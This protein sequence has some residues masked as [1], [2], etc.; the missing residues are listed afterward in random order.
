MRKVV[1]REQLP[2]YPRFVVRFPLNELGH[3]E[4]SGAPVD[5]GV[6]FP[7]QEDEV[8][9]AVVRASWRL[10]VASWAAAVLRD[11]MRDL[12]DQYAF[13]HLVVVGDQVLAAGRMGT[14]CGRTAPEDRLVSSRHCH[15]LS[16]LGRLLPTGVHC[17]TTLS[18][19]TGAKRHHPQG[20]S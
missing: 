16:P 2:V 6:V 18:L 1:V 20:A 10:L 9:L 17:T 8:R 11:D 15:F 14:P 19:Y 12:A 7:T 13:A 4:L 3:G 5:D